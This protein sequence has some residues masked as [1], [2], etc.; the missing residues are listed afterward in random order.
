MYYRRAEFKMDQYVKLSEVRK[1][2]QDAIH[3]MLDTI[4]KGEDLARN[5]RTQI[6]T[7]EAKL[8]QQ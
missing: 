7:I 4:R 6:T 1:I 5:N 2:V 8:K 3:S